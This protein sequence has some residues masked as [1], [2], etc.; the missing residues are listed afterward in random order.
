M[1]TAVSLAAKDRKGSPLATMNKYIVSDYWFNVEKQA[2][3]ILR[4]SVHGVGKGAF[5]RVGN[6]DGNASSSFKAANNENC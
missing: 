1:I 4:G 2:Q 3:N 5:I 6:K